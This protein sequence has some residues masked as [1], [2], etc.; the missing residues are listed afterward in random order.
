MGG[1][2]CCGLGPLRHTMGVGWTTRGRRSGYWRGRCGSRHG[3]GCRARRRW[4]PSLATMERPGCA[5]SGG[6]EA[7]WA[8]WVEVPIGAPVGVVKLPSRHHMTQSL[9]QPTRR[10]EAVSSTRFAG[11]QFEARETAQGRNCTWLTSELLV[12]VRKVGASDRPPYI[13]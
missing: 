4:G 9:T 2:C 12:L 11:N 1:S 10:R 8:T 5:G 7:E 3:D 13:N 6:A